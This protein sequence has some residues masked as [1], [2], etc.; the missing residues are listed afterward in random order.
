MVDVLHGEIN[1]LDFPGREGFGLFE[2]VAE[3]P[4]ERLAAHKLLIATHRERGWRNIGSRL[5]FVFG[6]GLIELA[7]GIVGGID[8]DHFYVPVGI[9]SRRRNEKPGGDGW[10]AGQS[11]LR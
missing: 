7:V 10:G 5:V 1:F 2:T 11:I 4:P 8:V 3:L 9:R 6:F